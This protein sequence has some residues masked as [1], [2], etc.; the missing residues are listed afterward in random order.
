MS[1]G[2]GILCA[3][4]ITALVSV[5]GGD[6]FILLESALLFPCRGPIR[7]QK[8]KLFPRIDQVALSLLTAVTSEGT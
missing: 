3:S 7:G 1:E 8:G 6:G 2:R 5:G 4:R